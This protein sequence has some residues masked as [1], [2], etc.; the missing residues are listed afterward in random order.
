MGPAHVP[1][2][3]FTDWIPITTGSSNHRS[4]RSAALIEKRRVMSA[5]VR[6]SRSLRSAQPSCPT[7]FMSFS[8]VPEIWGG[9]RSKSG[10]ISFPIRSIHA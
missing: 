9:V 8:F 10:C 1:M 7:S 3:P 4:S 5:T 6:S 2:I